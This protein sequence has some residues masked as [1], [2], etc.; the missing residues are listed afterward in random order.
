MAI[1]VILRGETAK[2]ITLRL[3]DGYDYAGCTLAVD[4]CGVVRSFGGLAPGGTLSLAFTDG[5]TAGFPLGTSK[6][7][8]TL[9]N[10]NGDTCRLPWA[11]IKVT[12]S[13]DEL[14]DAAASIDV[15]PA[16]FIGEILPARFTDEDVRSRLNAIINWMKRGAVGMLLAL[17]LPAFADVLNDTLLGLAVITIAL[18][19]WT[20]V[21]LICD[22]KGI[23]RSA[24][25]KKK[26]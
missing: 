2:P 22:P 18:V 20:A 4:F 19:I 11:K 6:A 15:D 14:R 3:A 16:T 13:P 26:A 25:L 17:A 9:K 5:E 21:F 12:D 24:L 10:G 1:P 23:V 8:L 7:F